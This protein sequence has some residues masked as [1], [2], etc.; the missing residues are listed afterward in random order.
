[1]ALPKHTGAFSPDSTSYHSCKKKARRPGFKIL[2]DPATT[3]FLENM[4]QRIRAERVL[5]DLEHG[6]AVPLLVDLPAARI[7]NT[8]SVTKHGEEF[9][10]TLAWWI[11]QGYV[12]GPF[13]APPFRNF[14]TNAMMAVEQKNKI[15]IIMNM[16]APEGS[17]Y[18]DAINESALEKV[19]MSSA[20]LFGYSVQ[21]C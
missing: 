4:D 21:D 18:N 1:M 17:P 14:R 3:R 6:S 12:A 2:C 19:T 16:S 13:A 15:R 8:P 9:T 10:D 5:T 11:R 20:R 7:P